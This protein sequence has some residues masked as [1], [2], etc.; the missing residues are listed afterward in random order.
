MNLTKALHSCL[1]QP[2]NMNALPITPRTKSHTLAFI[3]EFELGTAW[4]NCGMVGEVKVITK[5]LNFY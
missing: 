2:D 1:A 4:H 3:Q 5:L